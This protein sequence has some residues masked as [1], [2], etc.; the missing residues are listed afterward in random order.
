MGREQIRQIDHRVW[1]EEQWQQKKLVNPAFS[2]RAFAIKLGI[3]PASLSQILSGKRRLTSKTMLKICK[4]LTLD[5]LETKRL[6][7]RFNR[8]PDADLQ[9][10][11]L[12]IDVFRAIA[13]WYHFA[14]MGLAQMK[15]NRAS[16]TWISKRLGISKRLAAE[17]LTRLV[18]LKLLKVNGGKLVPLGE[19]VAT[20]DDVP[21][22]AIRSFHDQILKKAAVSQALEAVESREITSEVLAIDPGSMQEAKKRIREFK[23]SMNRYLSKSKKRLFAESSG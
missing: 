1:L 10:Q 4:S 7:V 8:V 3:S 5:P 20:K 23:L 6:L 14:I 18:K 16:K 17:A 21:S 13:N 11:I 19:R 2:L 9:S 12:Q 15:H 22:A